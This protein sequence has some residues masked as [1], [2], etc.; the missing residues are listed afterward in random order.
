MLDCHM[1]VSEPEKWVKPMADAGT[2]QYTF[3]IEATENAGA[4]I[5]SIKSHGMK[6][7]IAVKCVPFSSF[8]LTYPSHLP[9]S[10]S[11][12][13]SRWCVP[14]V[15]HFSLAEEEEEEVVVVVD[16]RC[17][18]LAFEIHHL[19]RVRRRHSAPTAAAAATTA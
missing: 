1:M 19:S 18:R 6:V 5:E 11:G 8:P 2:H 4:L 17:L 3:H 16:L 9:L 10:H 15:A 14:S 7:G 13:G 12:V